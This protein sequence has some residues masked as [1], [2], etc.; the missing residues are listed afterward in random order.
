MNS[1]PVEYI[2]FGSKVMAQA[3]TTDNVQ[4]GGRPPVDC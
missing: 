2:M 4:E 3:Q 1:I